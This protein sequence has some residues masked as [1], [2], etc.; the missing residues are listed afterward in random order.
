MSRRTPLI[1]AKPSTLRVRAQVSQIRW[2][3][4][5]AEDLNVNIVAV[6]HKEREEWQEVWGHLF[7]FASAVLKFNRWP[8]FLQAVM[9]RILAM[10]FA[11]YFDDATLQDVA[12]MCGTG[13][14]AVQ[15]AF[16]VLGALLAEDKSVRMTD[17]ADFDEPWAWCIAFQQHCTEERHRCDRVSESRR[18]LRLSSTACWNRADPHQPKPKVERRHSFPV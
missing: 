4:V 3:P 6:L 10:L 12:H 8:R 2:I 18:R 13:N 14:Q 17:S 11:M 7:G 9:R 15:T 1:G 5:G 16:K